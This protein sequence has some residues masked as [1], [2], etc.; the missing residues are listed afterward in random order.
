MLRGE[1]PLKL[2]VEPKGPVRQDG[3]FLIPSWGERGLFAA[4]KHSP[5]LESSEAG[6]AVGQVMDLLGLRR[7]DPQRIAKIFA[8]IFHAASLVDFCVKAIRTKAAAFFTQKMGG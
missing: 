2:T 5:R 7:V 3:P 1:K 6:H 8:I 4:N